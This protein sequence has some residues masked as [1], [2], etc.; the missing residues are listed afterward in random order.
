V[1]SKCYAELVDIKKDK[2]RFAAELA[3][4]HLADDPDMQI[5]QRINSYPDREM[6]V[7]EPVKVL[8]VTPQTSNSGIL[9][10][11]LGPNVDATYPSVMVV[12]TP[13]EYGALKE[14]KLRLPNQW[15]LGEAMFSQAAAAE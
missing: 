12:I 3:Q 4:S 9:P 11:Y 1:R 2:D 10:I 6:D 14:G 7:D 8:E 15:Q 5:I 13:E